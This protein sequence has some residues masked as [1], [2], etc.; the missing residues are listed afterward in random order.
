MIKT[1]DVITSFTF[2][3]RKIIRELGIVRG[4]TVRS[5]SVLGNIAGGVETLFGGETT[6]YTE[7]CER[8]RSDAFDRMVYNAEQL[9]ATAIIGV[10]YDANEVMQ[11]VT[12]VLCYGTAVEATARP[13]QATQRKKAALDAAQ[14]PSCG[15]SI[16]P[17]TKKCP[18]CGSEI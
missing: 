10:R 2:T 6:V 14:C 16:D 17:G 13:A 15:L 3:D 9:G 5:R 8:T 18:A 4:I 7:L 11:G 12:E 1:E